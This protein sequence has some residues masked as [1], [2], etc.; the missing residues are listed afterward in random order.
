VLRIDEKH[1]RERYVSNVVGVIITTNYKANGIYLP[2]DDRRHYIAWSRLT[3]DDFTLDYWRNLY[4]WYENG[5]NQDVAAYLLEFDLSK[6]DPKA[7]PE[8]TA[9]FG[10]IVRS[11]SA[12]EDMEMAD[13]IDRLK[14][15]TVVTFGRIQSEADGDFMM[16]L[17][18]PRNRRQIPHRLERCGYAQVVNPNAKDGYWKINDKRHSVYGRSDVDTKTLITTIQRLSTTGSTAG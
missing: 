13:V 10:D 7:P 1:I 15:P 8:K 11:N 5:G 17:R 12:P 2:P 14:N 3:R 9:A 6:F 16:W 18:D 4:G